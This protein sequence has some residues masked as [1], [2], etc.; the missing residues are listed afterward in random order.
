M[1]YYVITDLIKDVLINDSKLCGL[2][3]ITST[4]IKIFEKE[5]ETSKG[6]ISIALNVIDNYLADGNQDSL[7]TEPEFQRTKD[8]NNFLK[9]DKLGKGR[10]FTPKF[11]QL[12]FANKFLMGQSLAG[13][14]S[15][16]KQIL[17]KLK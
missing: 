16:R 4:V 11:E 17:D 6:L 5:S 10:E 9:W 2:K 3:E 12:L 7:F 14:Q 1:F 8:L 13:Q 15:I